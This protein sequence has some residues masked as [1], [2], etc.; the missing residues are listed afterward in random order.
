MSEILVRVADTTPTLDTS[1][2]RGDVIA[3]CE[4]GWPW[5]D[6]EFEHSFWRILKLPGVPVATAAILE[7]NGEGVFRAYSFDM[8]KL[9]GEAAAYIADDTRAR[10]HHTLDITEGEFGALVRRKPAVGV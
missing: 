7:K 8:D 1:S 5:G 10:G 9:T 2:R 3:V 4:D 6:K